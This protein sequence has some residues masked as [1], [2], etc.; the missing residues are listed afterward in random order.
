MRSTSSFLFDKV[1]LLIFSVSV[2]LVM[3]FVQFTFDSM[4]IPSKLVEAKMR[5]TNKKIGSKL[6]IAKRNIGS[7]SMSVC[8]KD[9][10]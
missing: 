7:E 4:K 3:I 5:L 9:R 2:S 6:S 1:F 8:E 10:E